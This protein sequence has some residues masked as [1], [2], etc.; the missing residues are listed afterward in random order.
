MVSGTK[1]SWYR[2][3]GAASFSLERRVA[4][5]ANHNPTA[6]AS[7][8]VIGNLVCKDFTGDSRVDIAFT[9]ERGTPLA[10]VNNGGSGF[11][12]VSQLG[13]T[14][15]GYVSAV[16]KLVGDSQPDYFVFNAIGYG[17]NYREYEYDSSGQLEREGNI[18][19]L[20]RPIC[21]PIFDIF[22]DKGPRCIKSLPADI[23][24]SGKP[25]IILASEKSVGYYKTDAYPSIED[26][27]TSMRALFIDSTEKFNDIAVGDINKD[28][29]IDVIISLSTPIGIEICMNKGPHPEQPDLVFYA[30]PS[31][32]ACLRLRAQ[33]DFPKGLQMADI[34][35]DGWTDI[36]FWSDVSLRPRQLFWIANLGLGRDALGDG[37]VYRD[38]FV[39]FGCYHVHT[40]QHK[41]HV[42]S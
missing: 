37:T 1:T 9:Q 17:F 23:Y 31:A 42:F 38:V 22:S 36:V 21:N 5:T 16:E 10:A 6:E 8:N 11:F 13:P 7:D 39:H 25:A 40:S 20:E 33:L 15:Y 41:Q 29:R 28:G 35:A 12:A 34:N 2:N 26:S 27:H 18:T 30:T 32:D 3:L 4:E 19:E 14:S 24:G